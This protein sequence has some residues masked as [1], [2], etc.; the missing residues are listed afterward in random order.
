MIKS[1]L[2]LFIIFVAC[3]TP[4]PSNTQAALT[5][6]STPEE[7]AKRWL[8]AYYKNDFKTAKQYSSPATQAMIDTIQNV[9]FIDDNEPIISFEITAL[10]CSVEE[11]EIAVCKYVYVE[12]R[13]KIPESITLKKHDGK[14]LVDDE[15]MQEGQEELVPLG[16][17][18]LME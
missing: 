10:H 5:F 11:V 14:W 8:V 9:L 6:P 1:K 7:V 17:L 3:E 16:E 4:P 12:E 15:L 18:D 13:E 2:L